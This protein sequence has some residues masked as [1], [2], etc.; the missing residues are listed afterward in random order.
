MLFLDMDLKSLIL[1]LNLL[2]VSYY[3]ISPILMLICLQDFAHLIILIVSAYWKGWFSNVPLYFNS[4]DYGVDKYDIGNGF[5]HFGIA[6]EDVSS[7]I[8]Y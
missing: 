5:G 6:V 7:F 2:I 1:L 4:T 3:L 8:N